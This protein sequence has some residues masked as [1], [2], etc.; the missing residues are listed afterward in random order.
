MKATTMRFAPTVLASVC[1][2]TL[3]AGCSKGIESSPGY[4]A[5]CHG[6]PLRTAEKRNEAMENGYS[7]HP[8]YHCVERASFAAIERQRAESKAANT[9]DAIAAR[10]A[11]FRA[12][13]ERA[14]AERARRSTA[15]DSN[16]VPPVSSLELREVD[17][18]AASEAQ[19]ASVISIGQ[20]TAAQIVAERNSRPFSDWADLVHRVD[21]LR[22]AQSA[23]QA[24]V[25][26][27]TVN[28]R[29]LDGAPPNPTLAAV[30]REKFKSR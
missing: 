25:C 16:T 28:G 9:P 13:R 1:A 27:L 2:A 18:N 20:E 19:I 15:E 10:E 22:A 26:G 14:N 8:E 7:I 21:G 17:V 11:E 29:S 23:Y 4:Q 6:P 3:F 24:S 12:Q 30:L 5:A